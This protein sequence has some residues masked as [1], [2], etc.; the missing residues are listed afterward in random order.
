MSKYRLYGFSS[1][2]RVSPSFLTPIFENGGEFY[3]QI[4]DERDHIKSFEKV[5]LD[6]LNSIQN[7]S[8][9]CFQEGDDAIFGISDKFS[10]VTYE[11]KSSLKSYLRSRIAEYIDTPF[12]YKEVSDFCE[13]ILPEFYGCESNRD[14][15]IRQ[16]VSNLIPEFVKE[17]KIRIERAR[18]KSK[19][20]T[21]KACLSKITNKTEEPKFVFT[22][23]YD[24]LLATYINFFEFAVSKHNKLYKNP[25]FVN[26][27]DS[28]IKILS[29]IE[30][31]DVY[32]LRNNLIYILY[33]NLEIK[34]ESKRESFKFINAKSKRKHYMKTMGNWSPSEYKNV[35]ADSLSFILYI[36]SRFTQ[37]AQRKLANEDDMFHITK[38][39]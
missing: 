30:D 11:T 24:S 39:E 33:S 9:Y 5:S 22:S 18:I 13:M 17:N 4:M 35:S 29:K 14:Y 20:Y 16:V 23:N 8:D 34:G 10:E 3:V 28:A 27:L 25:S 12:F 1:P 32:E 7:H 38:L 36:T 2:A 19:I 6:N 15:L 37:E 21:Y 31:H 26:S